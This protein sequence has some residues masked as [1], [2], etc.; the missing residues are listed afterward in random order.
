MSANISPLAQTFKISD[1]FPQGCFISSIDLFLAYKDPLETNSIEVQIVETLNGYPTDNILDNAKSLMGAVDV[2][3]SSTALVPTKFK[4]PVLI[5]LKPATEYAVKVI[6][7][8]LKYKAWTAVIGEPRVDNPSILITQQPALGSMFKS[9][10]NSTWTPEQLQDLTFRLNRAKFNTGVIGKMNLVEAPVSEYQELSPNPFKTTLNQSLVSVLHENHGLA[11]GMYVVYSGSTDTQFNSQFT[12]MS[13]LSSDRYTITKGNT[14]DVTNHVGG[15]AVKV[16]KTVK[17]D[18]VRVLGFE[19][20]RDVGIKLT[21]R[22]ASS[23]LIDAADT[24]IVPGE[25]LDMTSNKYVHSSI[26][27]TSK[28]AGANSFT[29]K[30]ELSSINDAISPVID[31]NELTVQLLSNKINNPTPAIV[32]YLIDGINVV[33]GSSNVSFATTGV[34]RCN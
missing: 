19:E 9:Q 1:E 11:A 8:S 22:M 21:S 7:N 17:Y 20:G 15:G 30:T 31:L 4:F 24:D 33:V 10:N 2:L 13:V 16:E 12:V 32:N 3:S 34:S 28:L 26:N 25:Y 27:R 29:L 18:T 23:A 6:S 5:F 14:T